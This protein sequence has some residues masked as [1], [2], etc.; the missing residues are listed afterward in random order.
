M[1]EKELKHVETG[2]INIFANRKQQTQRVNAERRRKITKQNINRE[3]NNCSFRA[4]RHGRK[5]Y[6]KFKKKT[7]FIINAFRDCY[8]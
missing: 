8:S 4:I 5:C 3:Q 6:S 1:A 2:K 7:R